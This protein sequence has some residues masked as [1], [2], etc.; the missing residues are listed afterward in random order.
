[1]LNESLYT[2]GFWPVALSVSG[3]LRGRLHSLWSSPTLFKTIFHEGRS[4]QPDAQH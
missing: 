4:A 3:N 1:M 2:H